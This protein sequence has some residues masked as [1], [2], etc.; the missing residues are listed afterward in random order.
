M[1]LLGALNLA[2]PELLRRPVTD[3][4][5]GQQQRAAAARALIGMPDIVIA[6]EPTSSLDAGHREAFIKLL[7]QECKEAGTS[8]VFVSH[9][10]SLA[11]FFDRSLALQ[12]IN[13]A[14]KPLETMGEVSL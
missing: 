14:S 2:D 1:R 6:D 5:V 8:L 9:D 11:R 7:F 4:S 10:G 3:L 13:R 12:A